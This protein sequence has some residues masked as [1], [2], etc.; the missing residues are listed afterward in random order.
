MNTLEIFSISLIGLL[1]LFIVM[2]YYTENNV[3]DGILYS[4]NKTNNKVKFIK[5]INLT[6]TKHKF[7][8]IKGKFK[9]INLTWS[10][11]YYIKILTKTSDNVNLNLNIKLKNIQLVFDNLFTKIQKEV[12]TDN[13]ELR[14]YIYSIERELNDYY[15]QNMIHKLLLSYSKNDLIQNFDKFKLELITKIQDL[16]K[17]YNY[18]FIINEKDVLISYEWKI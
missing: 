14:D 2:R 12:L 11:N 8:K 13:Y 4:V 7:N 9:F 16:I 15:I 5:Y 3:Y 18:P 6:C 10:N 17:D 1:I